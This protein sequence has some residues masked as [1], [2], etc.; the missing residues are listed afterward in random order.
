MTLASILRD[1]E[2]FLTKTF[3]QNIMVHKFHRKLMNFS[4]AQSNANIHAGKRLLQLPQVGI[5]RNR[6]LLY[7]VNQQSSTENTFTCYFCLQIPHQLYKKY[8]R[9]IDYPKHLLMCHK[10]HIIFYQ[11]PGM[12]WIT[13]DRSFPASSCYMVHKQLPGNFPCSLHWEL[14]SHTAGMRSL[15]F[16]AY[17]CQEQ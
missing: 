3:F 2:Y 17:V 7:C 13:A 16:S 12:V 5:V 1:R 6:I 9:K 15:P 8:N 11:C 14:T 10:K 4:E